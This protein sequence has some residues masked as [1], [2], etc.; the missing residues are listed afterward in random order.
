MVLNK[1]CMIGGSGFSFGRAGHLTFAELMLACAE[2]CYA[3]AYYGVG[4]C[5]WN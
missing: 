5:R 1:V 3:I 2:T 4:A